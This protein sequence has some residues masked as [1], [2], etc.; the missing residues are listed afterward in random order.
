M[1]LRKEFEFDAAHRLVGHKGACKNLHGHTW[2]VEIEMEIN[3]LD[4]VGMTWD[5]GNAKTIKNMLD[6]KTI[7][8][9]CKENEN[10]IKTI[11]ETCG[12]DSVVVMKGNPTAENL[13][14]EI[15]D[16]ILKQSDNIKSLKI[17]IWE[18]GTSSMEAK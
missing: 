5:F 8:K 10:L 17:I 2:R 3:K 4:E 11:E 15:R 1:I 12:I 13:S 14:T 7:L 6:H 18:S 16:L 9:K